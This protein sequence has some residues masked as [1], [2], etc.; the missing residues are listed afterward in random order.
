MTDNHRLGR[1]RALIGSA[2]LAGGL[3]VTGGVLAAPAY[4]T[5]SPQ[6]RP[7]I[8]D[9]VDERPDHIGVQLD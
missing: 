2:A 5:C 6:A 7:C 1:G 4:A 9:V 8:T 3:M